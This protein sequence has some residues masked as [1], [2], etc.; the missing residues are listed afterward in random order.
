MEAGYFFSINP[1]MV[2]S[3]SG[4]KIISKIPKHY[5]LTETDGPFVEVRNLPLKPGEI[6]SV[7]NYLVQEWNIT[8]C[9]V[10]N[11]ISSNFSRLIS[12]LK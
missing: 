2:K 8:N 12:H 4:R 1:T 3:M 6:S 11:I 7:I 9:D 5:I 10:E